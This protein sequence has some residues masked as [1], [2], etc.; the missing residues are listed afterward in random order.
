MGWGIKS[1]IIQL[2]SIVALFAQAYRIC[3]LTAKGA[4]KIKFEEN[5]AFGLEKFGNYK[6]S[7]YS[8][9]GVSSSYCARD[10][11]RI[12]DGSPSGYLNTQSYD[13]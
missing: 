3:I 1:H 6:T 13:R 2:K 7:P 11:L 9:S 10:F 5:P 12:P 4:C 8:R